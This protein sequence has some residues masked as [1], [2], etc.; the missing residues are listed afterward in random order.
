MLADEHGILRVAAAR[1]DRLNRVAVRIHRV[2]DVARSVRNRLH[3]RE[4]QERQAVD[5]VAQLQTGNH[6]AQRGVGARRTV[7]V[8]VG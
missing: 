8:V 6:P 5:G 4:V 7:A 1:D 3:R 2:D